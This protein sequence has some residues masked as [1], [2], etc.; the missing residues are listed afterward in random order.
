MAARPGRGRWTS[1]HY[2]SKPSTTY[3]AETLVASDGTDIIPAT[4]S[5]VNL[6]G[7]LSESKASSDTST[8]RLKVLV[9]SDKTATAI[10]S[11]G[12]GTA[13]SAMEGRRFDLTNS[14]G[15]DVTASTN[16]P[17]TMVKFISTAECE[18]LFN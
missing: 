4:S 3:T 7:I 12:T 5:S 2:R 18:F 13:T 8:A 17:V 9:P 1:F 16:D 11:I 14:A 15:V 6:L 10:I